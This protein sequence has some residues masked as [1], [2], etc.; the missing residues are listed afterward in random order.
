MRFFLPILLRMLPLVIPLLAA[1]MAEVLNTAL[2]CASIGKR[3][4]SCVVYGANV[5]PILGAMFWWGTMLWVPGMLLSGVILSR[6]LHHHLPP[7]WG[8]GG[9]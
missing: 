1:G 7:P 3:P 8:T 2:G 4:E 9:K 6:F 5:G